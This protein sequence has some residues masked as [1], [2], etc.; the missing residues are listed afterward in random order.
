MNKLLIGFLIGLFNLSAS[1]QFRV[2]VSGVGL[3]Q[4][5]IAV[6][7]FRGDASSPQKMGGIVLADLERSGQ[8][9]GIDVAGAVL[10]ETARP[11]IGV[12]RQK[13]AD[14]LVTGSVTRLAD[15]RY[16]VRV[17][18][19]DVVRNVDLGGESHAVVA[20]DLRLAA[21]RVADF[22]Y[23]KLTGD[24]G[25]FSTRIAYVTKNGSSFN[26][27]V[28]D[29]DGENAQSAL[30]S[31]EP[32]ISPSWAPNGTQLAYVSFESRKP[33][34]YV[35]DVASGKRRLVANFR[36]SNSAPAWSPDGRTLALT[37][38][39][40]GGSQLYLMD[41]NGGEPRRLAQS[42]SIDTEPTFTADGKTIYFV[43]DRGGSPQIYRVPVSGGNPERVTFNGTYN[44]S[45]SLSPDGRWL[46]YISRVSGAFRLHVQDLSSGAS[47]ALTDTSADENPSFSP[48]S[49]LIIYATQQQGREALMTSTLDGKI[50]ARLAGQNGDIREPDWGPVQK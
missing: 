26:L 37:L 34:V 43:S 30:N 44:I 21:H 50:K 29:A 46:A 22:V 3:T 24:K 32:I 19:W 36:G 13:S 27:W 6:A 33:V 40:D 4:I 16:D 42:S 1:A 18:L 12:W 8:F 9:R 47:N 45:P 25:I 15:G 31:P 11:D 35:H 48:N 2:E 38:T 41:A 7:A 17:R 23:E 28:A 20:G 14:A 49:R 39:R 5:P 10:D